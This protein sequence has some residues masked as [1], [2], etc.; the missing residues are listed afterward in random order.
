MGKLQKIGLTFSTDASNIKEHWTWC[1]K[2]F[3]E[4][5]ENNKENRA[6]PGG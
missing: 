6:V 2:N 1:V 5:Y 3:G 4:K